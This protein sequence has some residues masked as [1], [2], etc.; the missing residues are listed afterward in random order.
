MHR[1]YGIVELLSGDMYVGLCLQVYVRLVVMVC[2]LVA[3]VL[4]SVAYLYGM[5]HDLQGLALPVKSHK[6]CV[7][8]ATCF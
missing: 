8:L 2:K 4:T 3:S 7:H 1:F 6:H 5:A